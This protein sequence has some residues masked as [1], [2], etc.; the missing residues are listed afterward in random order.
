MKKTLYLLLVASSVFAAGPFD[1]ICQEEYETR[2]DGASIKNLTCT[3]KQY[4]PETELSGE[5]ITPDGTSYFG[6]FYSWNEVVNTLAGTLKQDANSYERIEIALGGNLTF[7]PYDTDGDVA[8]CPED[9]LSLNLAGATNVHFNGNEYTIHNFCQVGDGSYATVGFIGSIAGKSVSDQ[10]VVRDVTFSNAYVAL[11]NDVKMGRGA[12]IVANKALNAEFNNV[13]IS[14]SRVFGWNA[15]AVANVA[16]NSLFTNV[17]VSNV[18]VA[19]SEFL[20]DDE[21]F[22]DGIE[23]YQTSYKGGIVDSSLNTIFRNNTVAAVSISH[24]LNSLT[25]N[26]ATEAFRGTRWMGGIAGMSAYNQQYRAAN[27]SV[28]GLEISGGSNVGGMWGG[29]AVPDYNTFGVD[30]S[31]V[32]DAALKTQCLSYVTAGGIVGDVS[33]G[34]Y[35]ELLNN[36]VG[37][38][39]TYDESE[40]AETLDAPATFM[41]VGGLVGYSY[42][43]EEFL[44]Y[45]NEATPTIRIKEGKGGTSVY[46]GGLVGNAGYWATNYIFNNRMK[47]TVTVDVPASD[48]KVDEFKVNVG[49]IAGEMEAAEDGI[50]VYWNIVEESASISATVKNASASLALGGVVGFA[51]SRTDK[52]K[53]GIQGNAVFGNLSAVFDGQKNGFYGIGYVAGEI[54]A[55][56]ENFYVGANLFINDK[57]LTTTSAVGAA[58]VGAGAPVRLNDL[59][60]SVFYNYRNAVEGI[61]ADGS[62]HL[63]GS[64][65]IK[66]ADGRLMKGGVLSEEDMNSRLFAHGLNRNFYSN[67]RLDGQDGIYPYQM[68]DSDEFS[69]FKVDSK[70]ATA[71]MANFDITNLY[72]SL[73]ADEKTA[74][75]PYLVYTDAHL[76]E[77]DNPVAASARLH[78]VVGMN[79]DIPGAF[80]DV[81]PLDDGH[82]VIV[83]GS[84][85]RDISQIADFKGDS[86]YAITGNTALKVSYEVSDPTAVTA[87]Y[88]A[89]ETVEPYL[90]YFWPKVSSINLYDEGVVVPRIKAANGKEYVPV[91]YR[92]YCKETAEYCDDLSFYD[93]PDEFLE[94]G[95]NSFDDFLGEIRRNNLSDYEPTLHVIFQNASPLEVSVSSPNSYIKLISL[96]ENEEGDVA[97]LDSA[98]YTVD[99]EEY[100]GLAPLGRQLALGKHPGYVLKSWNA[101]VWISDGFE[102]DFMFTCYSESA[103]EVCSHAKLL[104]SEDEKLG[105]VEQ[106]A[107]SMTM[108][109]NEK[110]VLTRWSVSLDKNASLDLTNYMDAMKLA[111]LWNNSY[112]YLRIA[113]EEDLM[114]YTVNFQRNTSSEYF[115]VLKEGELDWRD[116]DTYT[117]ED[118]EE[119]PYPEVFTKNGCAIWTNGDF[120]GDPILAKRFEIHSAGLYDEETDLYLMVAKE[121]GVETSVL[122]GYEGNH[123]LVDLVQRIG[124]ANTEKG[125]SE[126]V[127]EF[128][129]LESEEGNEN[130]LALEL[131]DTELQMPFGFA[132]RPQMGYKLTGLELSYEYEEELFNRDLLDVVDDTILIAPAFMGNLMLRGTFEPIQYQIA[133]ELLDTAGLFVDDLIEDRDYAI[134]MELDSWDFPMHIFNNERCVL[135]WKPIEPVKNEEGEN[136]DISWTFFGGSVFD[137]LGDG[138][139]ILE[140][141]WG[142]ARQCDNDVSEED[143]DAGPYSRVTLNAKGGSVEVWKMIFDGGEEPKDSV[144][145]R[146]GDE[147]Y[148][149]VP[150]DYDGSAFR[151][152][153]APAVGYEPLDSVLIYRYNSQNGDALDSLWVK[154]GEALWYDLRSTVIKAAFI[155]KDTTVLA[156]ADTLFSVKGR[157][158][159]L[160]FATGK[161][162]QERDIQA[163]VVLMDALGNVVRESAIDVEEDSLVYSSRWMDYPL[164]DGQYKLMLLVQDYRD[165]LNASWDFAVTSTVVAEAES[166]KMVSLAALDEQSVDWSGDMVFYW[167]NESANYGD[168]WQYQKL[169][170]DTEID[171]VRGFWFSSLK[172]NGFT[173]KEDSLI[174]K[175]AVW[176]LDSVYSG[177]NLV[178]NPYG[179]P[180]RVPESLVV[181]GWKDDVAD[182]DS[183]RY[184]EPYEAAWVYADSAITVDLDSSPY[185]YEE[186]D[187]RDSSGN[188]VYKRRSLAKANGFMDWAI[189]AVLTDEKN[190][191][192]SWNVMGVGEESQILEPPAGMGNRVN[193]SIVDGKRRLAKSIKKTDA[194]EFQWTLNLSASSPRKAYL[195]FDGLDQLAAYGYR[196]FVT[197]DGQTTEMFAGRQLPVFLKQSEKAAT[198]TVSRSA[199]NV[200]AALQELHVHQMS[201][202][203]GVNFL[204]PENLAGSPV[205]VELVSLQ[206]KVVARHN[207]TATVGVNGAT[208]DAPEPGLY[209]TRVRI[210]SQQLVGK[211]LIK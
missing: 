15:A 138:R 47:G 205:I 150:E 119:K 125:V 176:E 60:N 128:D 164:A 122:V 142:N 113:A 22:L 156:L 189:Q 108:D 24:T 62:V 188:S 27:N 177:W 77:Y 86:S 9:L 79:R 54:Y 21:N 173:L 49:G 50:C 117:V 26:G 44:V 18:D 57:D 85:R 51:Q 120:D 110:F 132:V 161:F 191:A 131:P 53:F 129:A 83:A 209:L 90:A 28:T 186:S 182:Y 2:G 208:L 197:I 61:P 1:Y 147:N 135:G 187:S 145:Y 141:V 40:C 171:P 106:L 80:W 179:W 82:N 39:Y 158:V 146:F 210:A 101:D 154:D 84:H 41:G 12:A 63:D 52:Y 42:L 70:N 196:V 46:A 180:I 23:Y 111:G 211:A 201:N 116:S 91:D 185:F 124:N 157:A 136:I 162:L 48:A 199:K 92:F 78:C 167:W 55:A 126:I 118:D 19:T 89:I 159:F 115:Y 169:E 33:K 198:V 81:L 139:S 5:V 66:T 100:V 30:S 160:N 64:G 172:G 194:D 35:F 6:P 140:P 103:P 4:D 16:E 204:V 170:R 13:S 17:N 134:D 32:A 121:C 114:T 45:G 166:W 67:R 184:L 69:L 20:L 58:W 102:P 202:S 143:P 168:F 98:E 29:L 87:S 94:Y 178:A 133:F 152:H 7:E 76:D 14:Y 109:G 43:N 207:A 97:K 10:V 153:F 130:I 34:G 112:M 72:E 59:S 163:Q 75:E 36:E 104:S 65:D 105:S 149:L 96:G 200:V 38:S 107:S 8:E 127:H 175:E 137:I 71:F 190:H 56:T 192:D 155:P 37:V 183:L 206:G 93:I 151:V 144:L 25:V 88:V 203:L 74:M 68:W 193:L 11:K 31:Y 123:G 3:I 174:N 148:M 165:T 73:T 95:V 99:V 181:W 195:G